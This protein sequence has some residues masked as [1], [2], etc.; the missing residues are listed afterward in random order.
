MST[1]NPADPIQ[2]QKLLKTLEADLEEASLALYQTP[3]RKHLGLSIIGEDCARKL[4]L[5]FR[6]AIVHKDFSNSSKSNGQMLRLFNHGTVIEHAPLELLVEMGFRPVEDPVD[7]NGFPTQHRTQRYA[8][9]HVGGSMDG[10]MYLPAKFGDFLC[11]IEVKTSA[12]SEFRK[13]KSE[14]VQLHRYMHWCQMC[15]Y[16][17]DK[18][19]PYGLYVALNKDTDEIYFEFLQLNLE[20][21][22]DMILKGEAI[23]NAKTPPQRIAASPTSWK[24]AAKNKKC[25]FISICHHDEVMHKSCRSCSHGTAGPNATW[26]CDASGGATIPEEV[27]ATGCEIYAAIPKD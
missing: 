8:N 6:H 13:L 17:Y 22:K 25:P 15:S 1:F 21:G 14:G 19:A 20:L 7:E 3:T 10:L 4:W 9:G 23:V 5:D 2:V 27:V 26:T 18:G 24:C 16:G 12:S 11:I